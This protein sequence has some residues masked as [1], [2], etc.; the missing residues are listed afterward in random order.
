MLTLREALV[1]VERHRSFWL[2]RL[3]SIVSSELLR[4]NLSWLLRIE[5]HIIIVF[6]IVLLH[7]LTLTLHS[8]LTLNALVAARTHL[9]LRRS[10]LLLFFCRHTHALTL[11]L[12]G[13]V[14][15]S[16]TSCCTRSHTYDRTYIVSARSAHDSADC[17][18][19]HRAH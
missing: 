6:G 1:I 17:G 18:A 16:R 13:G 15:H 9:A 5:V 4:V 19:E 7:L 2:S 8:L 12:L 10:A 14:A 11:L 3:L